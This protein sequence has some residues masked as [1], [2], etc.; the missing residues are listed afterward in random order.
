MNQHIQQFN[1]MLAEASN[2]LADQLRYAPSTVSE[3]RRVWKRVRTYMAD[4]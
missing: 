2:Y 4:H 1:A 3:Y